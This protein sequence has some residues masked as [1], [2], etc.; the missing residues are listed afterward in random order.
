MKI[1][2][3]KAGSIL[4]YLQMALNILISLVYTPTMIR[5]LG[6]SEYGLYNTVIS[7]ISMLAILNLGFSSSYVRFFMPYHTKGDREGEARL[8]GLYLVVFTVIG[9]V[10]L[11]CGIFLSFNLDLVFK[12][13]L[14]VSEY[15]LA[16]R[17]MLLLTANMAISF[18][19][20]VFSSIVTA[21][22]KYVFLKLVTCLKTVC[23]PL[24][25]IA[26]LLSGFRSVA[27]VVVTI[28][29]TLIADVFY[30]IYAF[31]AL[32]VRFRF[33]RSS[34]ALFGTIFSY[35]GFIA[36]NLIVDQINNNIGKLVIG[37]YIGAAAVTVFAVGFT[38]YTSFFSFSSA[39]SSVFIPKVHKIV[40]TVEDRLQQDKSLT[41]LFIRVGRIQFYILALVASGFLFFGEPFV[42]IWSGIKDYKTAYFVALLLI[43]PAM[44]PL[45][46]NL[47]IEIQR[48]KNLQKFRSVAY[49]LMALVNI[50][51]GAV[52]CQRFGIIGATLGTPISLIIA[53]GF[54]INI[55]YHKRVG[56]DV[57][58]FWRNILRITA[59]LIPAVAYGLFVMLKCEMN[60][61]IDI[62]KL[63]IPFV[64]IYCASMWFISMNKYEKG[65]IT[66]AFK[67]LK[68]K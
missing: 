7:V 26:V 33:R 30:I 12:Q 43:I 51:L 21:H 11:A 29:V 55:Y 14:T 19:M 53:N 54:I 60:S 64:V 41:D 32:K 25:M 40:N 1:N 16:K 31:R 4:S 23:S 34:A 5:L 66:S 9:L 39:V 6:D 47:G 52:L 62:A 35:S 2:Q 59:G 42:R 22:E 44:I 13:G 65:L 27:M 63:A 3:L 8:N 18:P 56:L 49:L 37:R 67:K 17:L 38:L 68:R 50:I 10:A 36:V 57:I 46:Q 45:C 61:Y 20:S 15:A 28:A 24:L 48:A 58:S